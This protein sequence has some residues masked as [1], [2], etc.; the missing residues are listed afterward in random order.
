MTPAKGLFK[1][2]ADGDKAYL[3]NMLIKAA[4]GFEPVNKGFADPRLRPLGYAALLSAEG[5][6]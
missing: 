3:K 5:G 1:V 2:F 6:I 4:T